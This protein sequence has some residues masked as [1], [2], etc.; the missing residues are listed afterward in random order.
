MGKINLAIPTLSFY[1]WQNHDPEKKGLLKTRVKCPPHFATQF[2]PHQSMCHGEEPR[3]GIYFA[4][5]TGIKKNSNITMEHSEGE[6]DRSWKPVPF[7]QKWKCFPTF[8][9]PTS[10]VCWNWRSALPPFLSLLASLL[11]HTKNMS[12]EPWH[13]AMNP[14]Y[15]TLNA[16]G[17]SRKMATDSQ[18]VKVKG[19]KKQMHST[20]HTLASKL[21]HE[22]CFPWE[23][24]SYLYS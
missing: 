24:H 23:Q 21:C 5:Y 7:K 22:Q 17:S 3:N 12:P 14:F 15:W 4:Q 16:V 18:F 9:I 8:P 10:H 11:T 19:E 20:P 2:T 6:E 13:Q 1:E